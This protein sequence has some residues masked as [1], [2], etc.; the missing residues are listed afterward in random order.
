MNLRIVEHPL[1]HRNMTILRN[2]ETLPENFRNA[3]GRISML[4][5]MEIMKLAETMEIAVQTPLENTIGHVL[6]REIILAPVLRAGLGMVNGFAALVPDIKVGHIGIQRNESTLE[7]VVYY[8]KAPVSIK[9]AMVVVVDPMLATGGSASA[10]VRFLKELGAWKIYFASLLASPQG[11]QR[12]NSEHPDVEIFTA[13]L[14][15]EL[16]EKGYIL[17][18]LGD[19]GDRMFGTL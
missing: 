18:G 12:L 11:V 8:S 10:A 5:A 19:A 17:P 4:L 1:V 13:A 3:V 2:K 6:R 14:D 15:R 7:P 16:N 9:N